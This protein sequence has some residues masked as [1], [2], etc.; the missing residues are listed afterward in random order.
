MWLFLCCKITSRCCVTSMNTDGKLFSSDWISYSSIDWFFFI[1]DRK[2]C[3]PRA[4]RLLHYLKGLM[5]V[6]SLPYLVFTEPLCVLLLRPSLSWT[7]FALPHL[8]PEMC[9]WPLS[10][11][12]MYTASFL[13]ILLTVISCPE[14]TTVWLTKTSDWVRV[15]KWGPE[16]VHCYQTFWSNGQLEECF[17]V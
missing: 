1:L 15:K 17:F 7:S 14:R 12:F 3:L 9:F 10:W 13:A 4:V 2:C 8:K 11:S 16:H 6:T 5:G